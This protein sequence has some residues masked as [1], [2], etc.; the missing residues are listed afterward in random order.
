[1]CIRDSRLAAHVACIPVDCLQG[2]SGRNV[3]AVELCGAGQTRYR[4]RGYD[5]SGNNNSI[6]DHFFPPLGTAE[7]IQIIAGRD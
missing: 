4:E 7:T 1:M 2:A 5:E 3:Y 6:P